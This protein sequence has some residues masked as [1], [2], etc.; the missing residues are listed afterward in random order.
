M[1]A[2]IIGGSDEG[3][4]RLIASMGGLLP[5]AAVSRSTEG[6]VTLASWS[7]GSAA[8][9]ATF[10]GDHAYIGRLP[11]GPPDHGSELRGDFALVA[12]VDGRLRLSRA[13]FGGRPLYW[14]RFGDRVI[15]S[16]R[17]LPLAIAGGRDVRLN[18]EHVFALFDTRFWILDGPLPFV[19][20]HRVAMNSIV[21]VDASGRAKTSWG[22]VSIGDELRLTPPEIASALRA[23]LSAAV[24]RACAGARR[25][26]VFGGG[27]VD[28]S[29]L[30]ATAVRNSRRGGAEVLSVA[31]DYPGPGDDTP[32]LRA[33]CRHL[34]I[35]PTVVAPA[36]GAHHWG[37]ER[38][39]DASAHSVGPASMI[40]AAMKHARVGGAEQALFGD[41]SEMFLDDH[42]AVFG[43][44]LLADPLRALARAARREIMFE[45]RARSFI[46]L[47][48][49][50][51]ARRFIPA[52]AV[53]ARDRLVQTRAQAARLRARPWAGPRL[54]AFLSERRTYPR[55]PPIHGQR[56][57][58]ARLASSPLL[59][60]VREHLSRWETA[61][62]LAIVLP[63]LD[64]EF[65]R[66]T[67]RIPNDA[68]FATGRERGLLRES[69]RGLVPESVR[70]RMDKARPYRAFADLF[71]TVGGA[72]AVDE[73]LPMRGLAALGI[74]DPHGFRVAFDRFAADPYAVDA[75]W[76]GLWGAITGEAYVRWFDRFIAGGP[77]AAAGTPPPF[78]GL[79]A[80]AS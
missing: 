42:Q 51:L 49:G 65:A 38:V 14:A 2:A 71:G 44:F 1:I 17:L 40:L 60:G 4:A 22:P 66:F 39:V 33:L 16:N 36:E 77:S 54:R 28:S 46:R 50:P 69:M 62:G 74:I 56:E 26:A 20:A 6:G 24:E 63:Y 72:S 25:V 34:G 76:H 29:A 52:A 21:D 8:V 79:E 47:A 23:E 64:D 73:L 3:A 27:G 7:G 70:N 9:S 53:D 78:T 15:A 41:G 30:L 37:Q 19:G 75:D 13:R 59:T 5:G 68:M 11:D 12:R 35:E 31:F 48:V 67:G 55:P 58:V 45:S 57:R 32:H 61:G 18:V 10:A 80:R 43:A